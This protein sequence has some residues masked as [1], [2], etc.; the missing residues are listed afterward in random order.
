MVGV[1]AAGLVLALLTLT[2]TQGAFT[3]QTS[4]TGSTLTAAQLN[5]VLPTAV[6][7]TRTAATTCLVTW[8]AHGSVPAGATYD[9]TDGVGGTLATSV[10][11]SSVP[12]TVP[13]EALTPTVRTRVGAWVSTSA[14]AASAP[15]PGLPDAPVPTATPGDGQLTVTWPAPADNGS[16]IASYAA[17]TSPVSSTCTVVVPAAR[18]CTFTGLT[19]G[20]GHTVSV[21][22]T[23]A[24]GTGPAGTTTAI[25]YPSSIMTGARLTLWLDGADPATLLASSA[26]TGGGATTTVGCW[27]DKST[28][29]NHAS[30]A[31]TASRPTLAIV[32]THAV[33][34][35]DG[36]SG[37][38]TA[39][40]SLLPTGTTTS[41]TVLAAAVNPSVAM[42]GISAIAYG[43]TTNAS[44]RR[45][46]SW[47]QAG[48]D[49]AGSPMAFS[50]PWPGAQAQGVAVA[51]HTSGTS[52][53]IWANGDAGATSAGAY[54]TGT[55]HLWIGAGGLS[56]PSGHWKGTI[57]EVLVFSGALTPPERRTVQE[58]LAR[59]WGGVITPA[60]PTILT[61]IPGNAQVGVSWALPTWNGGAA[62]TSY[63]ATASPGGD[64]CTVTA[65]ATT[66]T[67]TGLTNGTAYTFTVT[68]TNSAGTGPAS[69]PSATVTPPL[70]AARLGFTTSP[71]GPYGAGSTITVQAA[72]QDAGGATVTADNSAVVTIAIGTN[73]SGGSLSCTN[74]GGTSAVVTSGIASFTCSIDTGG[75]GYTLTVTSGSLTSTTSAPFDV[76][77]ALTFGGLGAVTTRTS[78]GTATATYP[79]STAAGDL[80]LLM[81]VNSANQSITTPS[82]WTLLTDQPTSS[83]SQARTTLWWRLAAGESS[84]NVSIHTNSS[85]AN[86]CVVR[87]IRPGGYPPSPTHATGTDQ[88]GLAAATS[89][90]I[91]S[92]DVTTSAAQ[93]RVISLVT[94]RDQNTVSLAT[95]RGFTLRATAVQNI[96][97]QPVSIGIADSLVATSGTAAASPTW[98]QSGTAAQWSWSSTAFS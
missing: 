67:V 85:G 29:A 7:A 6:S 73:P 97:G 86:L 13:T 44:Q 88:S 84:V 41:T 61:A 94:V 64:S 96:S 98:S 2:S 74:P 31:T 72:V 15:C 93:A 48:I 54:S 39:N 11:G 56:T 71:S 32:N 82:G 83:P 78:S 38:L 65:P 76:T 30:Q 35:F 46:T 1:P 49:V 24:A 57:P 91:P 80:L 66:C 40:P 17:T 50:S 42:N 16:A 92:P 22:A 58:Y 62:I 95:P 89:S 25:P 4:S 47:V 27:K 70:V 14:T 63:T 33:P 81:E 69:T 68:A 77:G 34:S 37:H 59:K 36:S 3:S 75:S 53:S 5:A 43:G 55:D 20:L 51:E 87:Y 28:Q 60:A 10:S 9:V 19:N 52:V 23:S 26:C 90:L 18:T 45:V 21:T 12:V 79:A 8:A